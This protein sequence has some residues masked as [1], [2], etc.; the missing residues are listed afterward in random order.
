MPREAAPNNSTQQQQSKSLPFGGKAN[1]WTTSSNAPLELSN[2]EARTPAARLRREMSQKIAQQDAPGKQGARSHLGTVCLALASTNAFASTAAPPEPRT[3]AEICLDLRKAM[4]RRGVEGLK[5]IARSFKL[6]DTN[7]D[8]T[9]ERGEFVRFAQRCGLG[10]DDDEAEALHAYFDHDGSGRMDYEEFL[11]VVRGP[12]PAT[13]RKLVVDAFNALDAL[14]KN[15]GVLTVDDFEPHYDT[16]K[17]PDVLAGKRTRGEVLRSFL[18]NFDGAR[19]HARDGT[20]TSEEWIQYYEQLSNG[21][22]CDDFFGEMMLRAWPYLGLSYT[23]RHE[24]DALEKLVRKAVWQKGSLKQGSSGG[25]RNCDFQPLRDAFARLD[26]DRN[27]SLSFAEFA[28]IM[29]IFGFDPEA[30]SP[31][32]GRPLGDGLRSLF[33]RYD[34]D[35]SGVL[36]CEEFV[37]GLVGNLSAEERLLAGGGGRTGGRPAAEGGAGS[38]RGMSAGSCA[39]SNSSDAMKSLMGGY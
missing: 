27:G 37:A 38:L 18:D 30:T 16:T 15:D 22:D 9:L 8:G 5:A 14:G 24:V 33:D 28:R 2:S 17:H 36:S 26:T 13:R 19:A 31:F 6:V 11:Q 34:Y 3:Q 35:C 39:M 4:R 23:S 25:A 32:S 21:I 1:E 29:E 12:M 20:V 7:K 10:L